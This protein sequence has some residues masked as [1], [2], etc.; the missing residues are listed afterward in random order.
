MISALLLNSFL[1][2]L[3]RKYDIKSSQRRPTVELIWTEKGDAFNCTTI[4]T[5]NENQVNHCFVKLYCKRDLFISDHNGNLIRLV[6][7][8][9]NKIS[10]ISLKHLWGF[11]RQIG[12]FTQCPWGTSILQKI[13]KN[14]VCHVFHFVLEF[15][16]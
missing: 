7:L 13:P 12:Y 10:M 15:K 11:Y 3:S 14:L 1:F 9:M 4:C 8:W 6:C 16:K 2:S 5:V